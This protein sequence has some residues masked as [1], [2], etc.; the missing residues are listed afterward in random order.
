MF[1]GQSENR[2]TGLFICMKIKC[3]YVQCVFRISKKGSFMLKETENFNLVE[4]QRV[5][6]YSIAKLA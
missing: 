1:G 6:I 2:R 3:L 5:G 4:I